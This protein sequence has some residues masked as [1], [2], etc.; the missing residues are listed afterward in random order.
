MTDCGKAEYDGRSV[1]S[2]LQELEY[3]AK[4]F[5]LLFDVRSK[6][7]RREIGMSRMH[8]G[9]S[10]ILTRTRAIRRSSLSPVIPFVKPR[11]AEHSYTAPS[12]YR[13]IA[14]A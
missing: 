9:G 6:L 1:W 5:E 14:R 10:E 4:I 13:R 12:S 8:V 3:F 2:R 11:P 7:S